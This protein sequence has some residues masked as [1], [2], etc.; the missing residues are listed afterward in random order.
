MTVSPENG[1]APQVGRTLRGII[2]NTLIGYAL[3]ILIP[4]LIG[5]IV[6]LVD[7]ANAAQRVMYIRDLLWVVI[8]LLTIPVLMGLGI[9]LVQIAVLFGVIRLDISAVLGE[10]RGTFKAVSG[11][12]RFVGETVV[13]PII[14]VWT[15][16]TGG[17][18]FM[19]E[20]GRI[21]KVLRRNPDKPEAILEPD[22]PTLEE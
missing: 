2:R 11:T 19:R 1:D 21:V 13:A 9:L 10:I 14:R 7:S 20:L 5:L 6:S 4:L 22:D 3:F 8:L 16:F 12:A 15:F 18:T 17:L